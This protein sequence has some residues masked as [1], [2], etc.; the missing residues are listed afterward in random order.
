MIGLI[1]INHKTAPIEVRE[2]FVFDQNDIIEFANKYKDRAGFEG[3]LVLSTCNRTELYFVI[4]DSDPLSFFDELLIDLQEYMNFEDSLKDYVFMHSDDDAIR[5]L[6]KVAAGLDSMILGEY[7]IVS[8]LKEA[9][10]IAKDNGFLGATLIRMFHKSLEVGKKIRTNTKVSEGAMSV[11]YAAVKQAENL[12]GNFSDKNVLVIGAGETGQIAI[13]HFQKKGCE[14]LTIANRTLNK[15]ILL[16]QKTNS[17]FIEL[18][19][20]PEILQSQD[21]V[22]V[23]TSS[24]K[25]L[26]SKTIVKRAMEDRKGK[27]LLL[28]DLSVPRNVEPG[29]EEISGVELM[30]MDGLQKLVEKS[31]EIRHSEIEKADIFIEKGFEEFKEWLGFRKLMPA[32]SSLSENFKA[33]QQTEIELFLSKNNNKFEA[34]QYSEH[35][36]NKYI[37]MLVTQIKMATDNGNDKELVP[38]VNKIFDTNF[39]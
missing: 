6:F 12:L 18:E 5:H 30:D 2:R 8:Q 14:N 3:M 32:I 33:I 38:L 16:A 25:P 7:Q 22:I 37:R 24:Q 19:K 29:L 9:Y 28:I 31:Q 21:I 39:Q 20:I 27:P 11:S 23:S 26:I 13:K 15:A 35:I 36:A 10:F 4:H 17:L 34:K 1:G